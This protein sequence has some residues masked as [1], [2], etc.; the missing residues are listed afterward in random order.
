M[1][2]AVAGLRTERGVRIRGAG[3][4]DVSYPAFFQ[5]LE[6]IRG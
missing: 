2:A 5:T 4:V 6:Q 3:S 1:A